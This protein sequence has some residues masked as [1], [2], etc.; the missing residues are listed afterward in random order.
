MAGMHTYCVAW[1]KKRHKERQTANMVKMRAGEKKVEINRHIL[2]ELIAKWPQP[3]ACVKNYSVDSTLHVE[4][5]G[6]AAIA[7]RIG[8]RD[9]D[10]PPHPPESDVN[11]G[12]ISHS[13][14]SH[15]SINGTIPN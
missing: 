13:P 1:Y 5:G 15:T 3:G 9:R 10:A 8:T 7:H 2:R 12:L 11:F 4:S 14:P 6:I